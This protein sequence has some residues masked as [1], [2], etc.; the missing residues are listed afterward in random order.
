M[1]AASRTQ[2]QSLASG[3]NRELARR[4]ILRRRIQEPESAYR[5]LTAVRNA[6]LGAGALAPYAWNS[7]QLDPSI[8]PH[9]GP[10]KTNVTQPR[11]WIMFP[12]GRLKQEAPLGVRQEGPARRGIPV[13]FVEEA[14]EDTGA[15]ELGLVKHRFHVWIEKKRERSPEAV[16]LGDGGRDGEDAVCQEVWRSLFS[17]I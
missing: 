6:L 11:A 5:P 9:L 8:R 10:G 2:N 15:D 13:I 1:A 16:L 14:T 17:A 4:I 7:C 3:V 12:P